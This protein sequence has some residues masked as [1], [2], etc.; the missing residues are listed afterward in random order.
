VILM[1]MI[2]DDENDNESEYWTIDGLVGVSRNCGIF[3]A[4]PSLVGPGRPS[5]ED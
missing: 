3:L 2:D 4:G 5:H 1:M